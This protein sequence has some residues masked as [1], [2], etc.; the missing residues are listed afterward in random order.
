M[1]S[2]DAV[3]LVVDDVVAGYGEEPVVKGVSLTVSRGEVCAIVGPNGA[4]KSTLLKAILGLVRVRQ[5]SV[6]LYGVD[7]T[8]H[9]LEALARQGVGYVPQSDDVFDTL[10]V[11][12][13]LEL[14]GV[15]LERRLRAERVEVV[16]EI[17]PQLKKNLRQYAGTLSGGE[18]KMVAVARVLV[19]DP[20]AL[21][22]DEPTAGLAPELSRIVLEQQVGLLAGLGKAV[23]IVEQKAQAALK[24][25]HS[26]SVLVGGRVARTGTGE[27]VLADDAVAALFL[28]GHAE[29]ERERD[30]ARSAPD[31]AGP[32]RSR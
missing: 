20:L 9:P 29:D 2:D 6:R 32:S 16:L 8:N 27:Q 23:L 12:E 31:G 13:N 7:I 26:A 15:I 10:R 24:V 28:G 1:S 5:G 14:G 22:L 17:F 18:R 30:V 11:S 3:V 21:L 25:A 4:G 19:A